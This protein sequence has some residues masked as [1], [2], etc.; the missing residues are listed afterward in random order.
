MNIVVEDI[1][2]H[3]LDVAVT[4]HHETVAAKMVLHYKVWFRFYIRQI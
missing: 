4:V 2:V 1:M 3:F